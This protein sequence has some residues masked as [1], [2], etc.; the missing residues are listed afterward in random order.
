MTPTIWAPTWKR[1]GS[2]SH[3][4]SHACRKGRTGRTS[5]TTGN[6]PCPKQ[7]HPANRAGQ[8]GQASFRLQNRRTGGRVLPLAPRVEPSSMD[9]SFPWAGLLRKGCKTG[10]P[11]RG[12]HEI[13]NLSHGPTNRTS[14]RS[15]ASRCPAR[16]GSGCAPE[17]FPVLRWTF[18]LG[19]W[20]APRATP[21]LE[22][23][24]Q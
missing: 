22:V 4:D 15:G 6:H 16:C 24:L 1:S 13:F 23:I 17:A 2:D 12:R 8:G 19:N 7:S 10:A 5:Q 21:V 11:D 14:S 20:L 9:G 18:G 3:F